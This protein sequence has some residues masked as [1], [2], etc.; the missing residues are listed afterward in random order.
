MTLCGGAS[1]KPREALPELGVSSGR[2]S[3]EGVASSPEAWGE[4]LA[5]LMLWPKFSIV[6]VNKDPPFALVCSKISG[7]GGSWLCIVLISYAAK[8]L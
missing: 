6:R 8:Y 1:R 7:G 2:R 4:L 5:R 3:L